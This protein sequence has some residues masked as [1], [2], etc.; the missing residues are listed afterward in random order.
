[1]WFSAAQSSEPFS[2]FAR[3]EGLEPQAYELS[4]FLHAGELHCALDEMVVNIECGTHVHKYA[5]SRHILSSI[6]LSHH[7]Q[8]E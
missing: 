3:D 5:W 8:K 4:L 2:S 1:M 7:G 6:A